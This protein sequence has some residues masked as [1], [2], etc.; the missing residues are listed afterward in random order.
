MSTEYEITLLDPRG[1]A[2]T[3]QLTAFT[4]LEY[5]EKINEVGSMTLINPSQF[6]L[7]WFGRDYRLEI[8]RSI[9]GR[10]AY[11]EGDTQWLIRKINIARD[12]G[13]R[14]LKV[15]AY[16]LKHLLKRRIVAYNTKSVYADKSDYADDMM[17][18]IFSEN[19][20]LGCIDALRD[21]SE[22]ISIQTDFGLAMPVAKEFARRTV[23]G[24]F[25]ELAE[26]SYENGIY[27]A[28]DIVRLTT[29]NMEFR[30]YVNQR[31]VDHTKGSL[32]PLLFG[33][34][35]GNLTN[36]DYLDDLSEEATFIYAG[37][38]GTDAARVIRTAQDDARIGTSPFGRYE[39]FIDARQTDTPAD[40]EDDAESELRMRIPKRIISGKVADIDGCR[41]GLHYK[42]GDKVT[43]ETDE[44]SVNAYID[45]VHVTKTAGKESVDIGLE[46]TW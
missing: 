44:V 32:S 4:Q 31:G 34:K 18:E 38:Q 25:Q 23:L 2:I 12:G 16:D 39:Y 19:F 33:A 30:T 41:Y 10:P 14:V 40:V 11:L 35:Y 1:N 17:K 21:W 24:I 13:Q 37:G 29:S 22:W 43:V 28:F 8:W 3:K 15:T 26:Y 20:G 42:L 45:S 46:A 9:D 5:S 7:W 36:D 27:L 6:P